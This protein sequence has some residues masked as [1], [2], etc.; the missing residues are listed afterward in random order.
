M[1]VL[2]GSHEGTYSTVRG[3][4]DANGGQS[5]GGINL[6]AHTDWKNKPE[7]SSCTPFGKLL[8]EG[9]L[10]G[11]GF[12]EIG[13][14]SNLNTKQDIDVLHQQQAHVVPLAQVQKDGVA[15][16]LSR[17]L[18]RATATGP[19]FV[20]FDI[21]GCAEAYVP[22]VSA[23]SA[24]GFTPRQAVEAA[25]LAGQHERVRLFEEVELNLLYDRDNQM[26]RLAAIIIT[27]FLTGLAAGC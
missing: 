4:C 17:A 15:H 7:I 27:A 14:H 21:D 20:S 8:R 18:A 9:F 24:D 5:V 26:A 1:V 25:F 3:L 23:P 22:A 16:Y 19:A 13:L 10:R 6:D 2:G 12:T 11:E